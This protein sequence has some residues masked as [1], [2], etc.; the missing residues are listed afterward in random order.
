MK[1]KVNIL[2]G[3]IIGVEVYKKNDILIIDVSVKL[4]GKTESFIKLS[5]VNIKE[6]SFYWKNDIYFYTISDY[7]FIREHDF[8]YISFDPYDNTNK[9]SEKDNDFIYAKNVEVYYY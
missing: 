4:T 6:Y 3:E 7:T 8:V 1:N 5:F 2:D 9:I